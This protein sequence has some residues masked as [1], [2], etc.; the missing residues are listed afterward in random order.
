MNRAR[1][2]GGDASSKYTVPMVEHVVK[3][4]ESF[5]GSEVELNLKDISRISNVGTTSTFRILHTLTNLKFIFKNV[6]TG[7]YRLGPGMLQ[8]TW[9]PSGTNKLGEYAS[10]YLG[11]LHQRFNET[12]NLAALEGKKIIYLDIRESSRI[13]RMTAS[14]GADL[15]IH[16]TALGKAIGALLPKDQLDD[17]LRECD[18]FR[19]TPHTITGQTKW[20]AGLAKIRKQGYAVDKEETELGAVCIAAPILDRSKIVV[21][22]VS[23][24]GPAPRILASH[25]QIVGDLKE[26]AKEIGLWV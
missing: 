13:F 4:L 5:A 1:K 17:A 3:I 23:I 12:V 24:S 2:P 11:R 6:E 9:R 8:A 19:F 26:A 21:G 14:I 15:P 25:D 7:K 18:W 22:G 10:P 16:A 20:L